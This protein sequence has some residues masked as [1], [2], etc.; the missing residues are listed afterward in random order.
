MPQFHHP[1][2]NDGTNKR[3]FSLKM[4]NLGQKTVQAGDPS[5]P[6]NLLDE[7][8]MKME[9]AANG[10]QMVRVPDCEPKAFAILVNEI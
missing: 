10:L 1:F 4:K 5:Q 2:N 9:L 3:R 7:Q 6:N 8:T